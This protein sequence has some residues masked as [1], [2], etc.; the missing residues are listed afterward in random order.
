MAFLQIKFG[1]D[2][3]ISVKHEDDLK[4]LFPGN[5][6]LIDRESL[7]VFGSIC[8]ILDVAEVVFNH[9]ICFSN[10]TNLLSFSMPTL[11]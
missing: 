6:I 2:I 1:N 9:I 3:I 4:V 10:K 11:N 7:F 8:W 5:S